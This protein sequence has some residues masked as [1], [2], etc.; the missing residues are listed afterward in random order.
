[1]ICEKTTDCCEQCKWWQR[2]PFSDRGWGD[3]MRP[4]RGAW[5]LSAPDFRC[6]IFES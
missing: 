4:N 6:T 3:C 5:I 2:N 1:M